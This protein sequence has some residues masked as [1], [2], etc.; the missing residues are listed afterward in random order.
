MG[1]E[2]DDNR[3]RK[4]WTVLAQKRVNI[5]TYIQLQGQMFVEIH[6]QRLVKLK[7]KE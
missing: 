6:D 4:C 2:T 1:N 3:D 7:E 5:R